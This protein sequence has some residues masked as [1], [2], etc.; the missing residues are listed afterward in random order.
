MSKTQKCAMD[1]T[2]YLFDGWK[3]G[4][5][6]SCGMYSAAP[7]GCR[8]DHNKT[9]KHF[10]RYGTVTSNLLHFCSSLLSQGLVIDVTLP[11]I[12]ELDDSKPLFLAK[13]SLL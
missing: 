5:V 1:F 8:Y 11:P 13:E 4:I 9:K 10:L 12:M 6:F 2:I 3:F 7:R